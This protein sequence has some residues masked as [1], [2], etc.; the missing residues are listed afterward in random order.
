M[1]LPRFCQ[2]AVICTSDAEAAGD[3]VCRY[4]LDSFQSGL[5]VSSSLFGALAGSSAAF[6]VGDKLG[7]R[8]ELL[9]AAV[10]YGKLWTSRSQRSS[11]QL[12]TLATWL[13]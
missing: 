9:L 6:V 12:I 2:T 13:S 4:D 7:R 10:L 1:S 5:V 11:K 8:R 3:S